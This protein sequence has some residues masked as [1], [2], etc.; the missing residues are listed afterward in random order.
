[1]F[2]SPPRENPIRMN[3]RYER[4]RQNNINPLLSIDDIENS[5]WLPVARLFN[6]LQKRLILTTRNKGAVTYFRAITT[7]CG[8]HWRNEEEN[9][10][11]RFEE[12]FTHNSDLFRFLESFSSSPST[13]PQ[14]FNPQRDV[15]T[16]IQFYL[17]PDNFFNH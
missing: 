16:C 2:G 9:F 14:V 3:A 11:S 6:Q 1:M 17:S 7:P 15:F 5:V 8:I 12:I 10:F 13:T 4:S